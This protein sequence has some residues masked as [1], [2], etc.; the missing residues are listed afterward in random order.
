[1]KKI[2]YAWVVCIGCALI[3]F[4]TSGL[5]VNAFSIY[6]P[7]IISQNQFSNTQLSTMIAF[8]NFASL[9]SLFLVNRYYHKLGIRNGLTLIGIILAVAFMLYGF[10]TKYWHYC[11]AAMATGIAFGSGTM[12]PITI[13]LSR[14]FSRNKDTAIGICSAV[15]GLSTLG[16]PSL[17]SRSIETRGLRFTFCTEAAI[18]LLFATLCWLMLK[19]SPEEKGVLPYGQGSDEVSNP[20]QVKISDNRD[21]SRTALIIMILMLLLTGG[22]MNVAYSHLTVLITGVGL[23]ESVAALAMSLSGLGLMFGKIV[24]GRLEDLWGTV[25][26]NFVFAP[27]LLIGLVFCCFLGK[28]PFLLYPAMVLYSF[29]LGYLSVGLSTWP[30][31]LSSAERHDRMVQIFQI[32]Y[33]AGCLL[34]SPVPGIL[35]DRAGGSYASAYGLFAVLGVVV[36]ASVQ[37]ILIRH[38]QKR[39]S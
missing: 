20:S 8:R 13:L 21:I 24:Y 36:F 31:E 6:Q 22:V 15:T 26:C 9:F 7:Y 3:L 25:R 28:A 33:M 39:G 32:G 2:H 10:A 16:I 1:M 34:F 17:L 5:S 29:G 37:I 38:K 27:L 12:V 18:I 14:W 11:L 19:N 35:A 4:C 30:G 23:S